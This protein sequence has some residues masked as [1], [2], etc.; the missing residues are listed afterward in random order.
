MFHDQV[1][2]SFLYPSYIKMN[3]FSILILNVHSLPFQ[4]TQET[5]PPTTSVERKEEPT[6]HGFRGFLAGIV[7]GLKGLVEA[8]V[9]IVE[10]HSGI[11]TA[12]K[13]DFANPSQ[14][15]KNVSSSIHRAFKENPSEAL[16]ESVFALAG[17]AIPVVGEEALVGEG[18][19]HAA[20]VLSAADK[21]HGLD[22]TSHG[23]VAGSNSTLPP[24][25][26]HAVHQPKQQATVSPGPHS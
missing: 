2:G 7:K 5:F 26:A 13:K 15:A 9:V 25:Q 14:A 8:P 4:E 6:P 12:V 10:N 23:I 24:A 3:L 21:V 22:L 11:E 19:S 17:L 1:D 20:T 18:S 16:G